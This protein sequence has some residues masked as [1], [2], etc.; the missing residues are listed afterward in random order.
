MG[1]DSSPTDDLRLFQTGGHPCGYWPERSARDLVLDPRDPRLP[2]IYPQALDWGF[3]RSGDL[4]YRPHCAHCRA[5]VAVRIPVAAFEPDRSQ[6]RCLAR[7]ATVQTRIATARRTSEHFALYQ[8]YLGARHRDGGMDGHGTAEFDQFLVGSWSDTRFIEMREAGEDGP[9][10]L[11]AVAVTDRV[12][13][14]LSAVYT[15]Y[16]PDLPERGLGTLA[17]LHQIQWAQR[18]GLEHLYLGYWIQDHAKMDYK[19]R[20]QPLEAFDGRRWRRFTG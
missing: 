9:G 10:R 6:R 11:L 8:R 14:G 15:F 17:I 13:S 20:F 5:C 7:N 3:R 19:R 18:E 4:V 16:D 12:G 1:N 2:D